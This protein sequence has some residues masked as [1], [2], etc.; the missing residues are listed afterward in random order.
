MRAWKPFVVGMLV[1]A[2]WAAAVADAR[3]ARS[4]SEQPG[5]AS[6]VQAVQVGRLIDGAGN[7]V[8]GQSTIIVTGDRITSVEDGWASPPGATII[9][10]RTS[11]A[12]PGLI[13]SHT[14]ITSQGTGNAMIRAVTEMPVDAAV[15]S[16]V[17][18]RRTL[19]AGFTTIR[20]VGADGGADVALKRAIDGG[21]LAGP[22][23]WTARTTISIT[24]GHGDQGGLRPDLWVAPTWMDGIVDGAD[25]ARKAVRYQHKY[26]A[27]LIKITATGGVL[28]IGDSGDAQQFTDAEMEAIVEAAHLLGIKVAAHA[29][30]KQG[31][32][33]AI[34]AGVDSIEHGTYADDEAFAAFREHGTYLVP[35]IIAGKTVAEM[36][37]IPGHFHP[38]VEEKAARIGPLIQDMFRRAYAA[39]VRIAFGTDSGVSTH[40]ENAREFGYMVEAGMPPIEAILSATRA[41]ADLL[42]A[43]D[44]IGSIQP[45]R[46]ADV[47]AVAGDPVADIAE[48]RRVTFV[49][50]GGVVYKMGGTETGAGR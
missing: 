35:T 25:E 28:S 2:A 50:K 34:K 30:G 22:R 41:A 21:L 13:D 18:A 37:T 10:L 17:Y 40:G 12:L 20:N 14:H 49:M 39:G 6:R 15:K 45:G 47:I 5:Q 16:T 9:D 1:A 26:G 42:G 19:M 33:A 3:Q 24:G 31:I 46:F 27:D 4:G 29:H 44:H 36:A 7:E 38:T 11:T 48:L 8:R 43:A 23:I 32:I